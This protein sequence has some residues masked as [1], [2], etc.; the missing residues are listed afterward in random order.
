MS[1]WVKFPKACCVVVYIDIIHKKK[2]VICQ[3]IT[4]SVTLNG[5]GTP[6][7]DVADEIRLPAEFRLL[8]NYPNPFNSCTAIPYHVPKTGRV[9]MHLFDASG[10]R[11]TCLLDAE[12]PPG[13]YEAYWDSRDASG[14]PV[15]SGVYLVRMQTEGYTGKRKLICIK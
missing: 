7:S 4:F 8:P 2:Q 5:S 6:P 11:V 15:G 10:R 9:T 13:A 3:I 14:R 12:R 1:Y